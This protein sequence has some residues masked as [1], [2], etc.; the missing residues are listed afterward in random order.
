M[1][2]QQF[3]VSSIVMMI[4]ATVFAVSP[5]SAQQVTKNGLPLDIRSHGRAIADDVAAN[6]TAAGTDEVSPVP[7]V[8]I[9]PQLQLRGP[10]IQVNDES[11]DNIQIFSGFRPFVAFT[12]SEASVAAFGHHIVV[13]YNTSDNQ[14]LSATPPPLHFVHRFLSGFSNSTDGGKTWTSGFMPPVPGSIFTFGD[15]VV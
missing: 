7:G 10:N 12:Q 11:L 2:R 13:T 14:P 4:A 1:F 6:G 3:P 8:H 5:A 9:V 15:G